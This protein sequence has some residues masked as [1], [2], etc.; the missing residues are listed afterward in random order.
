MLTVSQLARR[1]GLSRT[2]L[3]YYE[4][5]GLLPPAGRSESNYRR[6]TTEQLARLQGICAYRDAGLRLS[7]IRQILD[8]PSN[9]AS[10][11][12]QRRLLEL[13]R[14]IED[15]REHQNAILRLLRADDGKWR[16]LDMASEMTKEKWVA[17]MHAAGF[18]EEDMRRWHKQFEQQAPEEH[19]QFLEYLRIPTDE[20]G[21]IR[22]WS[23]EA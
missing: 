20:I 6:Y 2:T 10:T 9:A 5:I 16:R 12:L 4:S 14:E 8:E 11:V 19:Q 15:L 13:D 18:S 3:L 1:C 7:D 22:Q 17:I 23:R 21:S